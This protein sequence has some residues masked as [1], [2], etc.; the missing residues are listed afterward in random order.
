MFLPAAVAAPLTTY[1]PGAAPDAD[2]LTVSEVLRVPWGSA[3]GNL[4]RRV[5]DEGNPACPAA[6]AADAQGHLWVLDQV[7]ARVQVFA[8]RGGR[9]KVLPLPGD[10]FQDLAPDGRG[11]VVALDRLVAA[12]LA[13]VRADGRLDHEVPVEGPG[14]PTGGGVTALFRHADGWWVEYDHARIVR[15]ASP[16]GSPDTSRPGLQGRLSADASML[17]SAAIGRGGVAITSRAGRSP[18][19]PER[20][21][22]R[23]AFEVPRGLRARTTVLALE[24]DARGGVWLAA[25]VASESA[26]APFAPG[27]ARVEVR[28]FGAGGVP[29]GTAHLPVQ[30]GPDETLRPVRLGDDGALYQLACDTAGA[31]VRRVAP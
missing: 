10:S 19:G 13:F 26:S 25:E 11:G 6:L 9:P 5:P 3:V 31:V 28:R 8:P 1:G 30:D 21:F 24:P 7:N 23:V 27:P 14:V 12:S 2:G 29:A 4:G 18:P 15:V 16:D 17:F 20:P 22:A